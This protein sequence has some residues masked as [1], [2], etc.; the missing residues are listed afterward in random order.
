MGEVTIG[1]MGIC[2]N[3]PKNKLILNILRVI[4]NLVTQLKK[5]NHKWNKI[6]ENK[7]KKNKKIV[8]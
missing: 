1:R 4:S 3:C 2:M 6:T 5:I 7:E 8:L